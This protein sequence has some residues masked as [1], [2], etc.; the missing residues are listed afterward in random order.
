ILILINILSL[1]LISCDPERPITFDYD[2]FKSNWSKWTALN[3]SNYSFDYRGEGNGISDNHIV[4]SNGVVFSVVTNN[5]QSAFF[6]NTIDSIFSN[7]ENG[8]LQQQKLND[9]EL[10]LNEIVVRY[11]TNYFYPEYVY[12]DYRS[13]DGVV[14]GGMFTWYITN[15]QAY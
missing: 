6:T 10:Y 11:S 3:L 14:I 4:I 2:T 15:F 1:F 13:D 12:Y 7:I 5:A 9:S 8:Y